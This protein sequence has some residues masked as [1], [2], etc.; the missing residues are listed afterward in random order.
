MEDQDESLGR[1]AV[2]GD[3]DARPLPSETPTVASSTAQAFTPEMA[4]A[5]GAPVHD[6]GPSPPPKSGDATTVDTAPDSGIYQRL[7]QSIT[8]YAIYMLDTEGLVRTWNAGAQRAKGYTAEEIVG[9]HYGCFYSAEDRAKDLPAINLR[10]ARE[11]GKFEAEGWRTRKDGSQFWAHVVIDP[12]YSPEGEL[13]GYGKV[14]RDCTSQRRMREQVAAS[15]RRFK[16]LVQGVT[17]YAIYMLDVN[18]IVTNWNAGAERAKGYT[19]SE[20]VGKHFSCFHTQEDRLAGLPMVSLHEARQHGKFQVEGWRVRKDGSQFW[21][22]VVIDPIYD[23][24]GELLGFGKVT[25]DCTEARRLLARTKEQEQ[26]FRALVEGVTDYA[27]YML[28][29][30][31]IVSNW[32]AGAERAKGYKAGEIVGKHFSTFYTPEDQAKGIPALG[33]ETAKRVG[34][35][36]A[37]GWRV[38]KDG[39]QFWAHVV[40]QPVY[41]DNG[42]LFGFAK[43]TRDCSEQRKHANVL[44]AT[45]QNLNLALTNMRQG[46]CLFNQSGEL[47]LSNRRFS[48]VFE[49]P[50]DAL[51]PGMSLEQVVAR[52]SEVVPLYEQ[53][54]V[55]EHLRRLTVSLADRESWVRETMEL[56]V[57]FRQRTISVSTRM[58]AHGGW[59]S[60]VE[61]V[62]EQRMTEQRIQHLA[63][64]DTLT[65]LPNRTSFQNRIRQLLNATGIERSGFALLYLDLDRFKPV[66]DSLGHHIGDLL[67][68]AVSQRLLHIL[69]E[70]EQLA[71][72]GGDEFT[73]VT[74]SCR[75][76]AQARALAQR[77]IDQLDHPFE[78]A[79]NEISIGVSVG[80]VLHA[81]NA[82]DADHLLQQADLALYKA[83]REGRNRFCLY[84]P[85]MSDPLRTRNEIEEDLRRALRSDELTLHYQPIIDAAT[86]R[87]TACEALLRWRHRRRGVMAPAQFIPVAEERG[88]MHE[89]GAWVMK[90]ACI[91]AMSWPDDVR[92]SLNVSPSQLLYHEFIGALAIALD[93]S[94]FPARRLELEITETALLE[95]AE[96]PRQILKEV[97]A[98]GIG[99]AM[100]D[101]G[102]GYSSLSLLQSFPFTRIK[103]D[104][105]FIKELGRNPKSMAIV[106]SVMSLCRSLGMATIAEGVETQAQRETLLAEHCTELQGFLVCRPMPLVDV[107]RWFDTLPE[108]V[109]SGRKSGTEIRAGLAQT[110]ATAAQ[111]NIA[112]DKA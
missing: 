37:E 19:A 97:R 31:G 72:L 26:R 44:A 15:E 82:T 48:D 88:M 8:D 91:D 85:G 29:P 10:I 51:T 84:E 17:D 36:D 90:R 16:Y 73:I 60:T 104:R 62:T 68:K 3:V 47:V 5:G 92:L 53:P 35:F 27:I 65:N 9:R 93:E 24:E 11:E 52:I 2:R 89:L 100:D 86:G 20:I 107:L 94:G 42:A 22:H 12:L 6:G 112:S 95:N 7:V 50:P 33:I 56:E 103:V 67:L 38:R 57:S 80:V 23:D 46:L 18:G 66:N 76:A 61:D 30:H 21:A 78:I 28:D 58:L 69:G 71:R 41:D 111:P 4:D 101:F 1:T 110:S 59:V 14:T 98:M 54:A 108:A 70:G 45:S 102:T 75:T 81:D 83:K 109:R 106:R 13:F 49:L 39:T 96:T 32:N 74:T 99:V 87:V 34:K 64:H 63:H 43:I 77:C 55:A 40:I 105:S 79:S 25:R